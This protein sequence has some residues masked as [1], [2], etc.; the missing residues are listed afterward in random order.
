ML[1]DKILRFRFY[2]ILPQWVL[3]ILRSRHGRNEIEEL[4]T[5]NQYSMRNISQDNIRRIR[6]PIPSISEQNEI[7]SQIEGFFSIVEELERVIDQNLKRADR[8]RQSI[9]KLAFEGKLVP[10]NPNEEP[11]SLLLK[12]TNA[13]L[14]RKGSCTDRQS[15]P[16]TL[17]EFSG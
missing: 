1:S 17:N 7:I 2:E 3:Y 10:Q 8:F 6:L 5:G 15:R 9:L 11:D 14:P 16:M 12:L 13:V 4:A